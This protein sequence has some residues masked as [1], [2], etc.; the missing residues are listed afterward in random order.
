MRD[1]ATP[2][3]DTSITD[4]SQRLAFID[5]MSR[6]ATSV[7]LVTTDGPAGRFGLTVS[8]MASVT[9][10]PPTLLVCVNRRN[11]MDA[12]I[13]SNGVFAVNALRADQRWVAETFAGRPRK[14][15]PYDFQSGSWRLENTGAPLLIGAVAW[16]DCVLIAAHHVGTHTIAIGR[17]VGTGVEAG[18]PLIY[19]RRSFGE[20][21]QLPTSSPTSQELPDPV[22]DEP[23]W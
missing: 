17:V 1:E 3:I 15:N 10:D 4:D 8:S 11:P 20:L 5:G 12:A 23:D 22:W 21:V 19:G 16:F 9:A 14:G 7:T 2:I 6:V 18:T 13:R